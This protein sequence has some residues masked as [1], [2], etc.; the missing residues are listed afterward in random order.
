MVHVCVS[1]EERALLAAAC[2]RA[3]MSL[4][5]FMRSKAL[6]AAESD[7]LERRVAT[8]AT[9]DW[10]AFEAWANGPAQE[11]AALK[12]LASKSPTWLT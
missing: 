1:K 8:I 4:N 10:E 3:D 11:K 5:D 9:K 6:D 7:I 2:Q 12:E